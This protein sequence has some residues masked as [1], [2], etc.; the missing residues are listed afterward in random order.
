MLLLAHRPDARA[1]GSRGP[2]RPRTEIR[3][4]PLSPDDTRALVERPVRRADGSRPSPGC[5]DLIVA[6]A[7]GNPLFVEEIVRS[8][9]SRGVLV[10]DGD[11][12]MLTRGR[13]RR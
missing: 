8:L 1:A 2:R 6:R 13:R 10:R 12:W 4:A 5:S 9:V 3:L 7:G 11:R